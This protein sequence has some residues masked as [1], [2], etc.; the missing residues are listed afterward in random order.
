MRLKKIK[1]EMI[2]IFVL[3]GIGFLSVVYLSHIAISKFIIDQEIQKARLISHTLFYTR[4]YLSKIAP[5]VKL[6]DKHIHPFS[7]APAVTVSGIAK[8]IKKRENFIIRQTSDRYRNINNKPNPNEIKAIEFF[9][10]NPNQQELFELEKDR[11][12][13][14][15]KR[16]Y[17]FYPLKITQDCL[18]CHGTKKDMEPSLY[19][20][21]VDV[22]GE[23][24]FGYKLGDIRG[25]I[26][27]DIPLKK[28]QTAINT[29]F[30]ILALVLFVF[31]IIGVYLF[32]R[33]NR[34]IVKDMDTINAHF[35]KY[36]SKNIFKLLKSQLYY[37]EFENMKLILNNSI[38]SIKRLQK[39][40]Y[41]K[42]YYN[43]L[44]NLPNRELLI[45]KLSRTKDE[46]VGLILVDVDE[47]KDIN[48]Q[49]GE[50]IADR[51]V[52]EMANRL[53][54]YKVYHI[55]IDQFA[56][57]TY[58]MSESEIYE[59]SKKILNLLEKPYRIDEY[60]IYIK[61]RIGI[62]FGD[63][64]LMDVIFTL[65]ATK[66]LN[67]DIVFYKEAR[68]VKVMH[69]EHSLWFK[70]IKNALEEDRIKA[71]YQPIVDENG[72]I[73]KYEALVRLI[74][75]DG[76]VITPYFFLDIAKKSRLYFDITRTVIIQTFEKFRDK[77][78]E[79]SINLSTNDLSNSEIR[80]FIIEKVREFPN[81]NRINFEIIEDEDIKELNEANKFLKDLKKEGCKI[82]ID[83]FGS[84]YANFDYLL[85]LNADTIKIDG[86][87]IRNVL[88]DKHSEIIVKTIITFA[89]ESKKRVIA[90]YVENQEIFEKLKDMGV[91]FFQGYYFSIPLSNTEDLDC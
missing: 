58:G 49:Y 89:K 27:V 88:R 20:K 67:K 77:D 52:I 44:T 31:Y 68:E 46:T 19:K 53:E 15:Y 18:K 73:I 86:S 7:L 1:N 76:K 61:I 12:K 29:I 3:S 16:L 6:I 40:S 25:V 70:K 62:S 63:K 64:D 10:K 2:A 87:L 79:I 75:A 4:E 45:K 21:L 47:F 56:I 22:Y 9:K 83:D 66:I 78:C 43:R 51:L 72:K 57:V 36:F 5:Y 55:K 11:D 48:F 54:E 33:I 74:D 23:R 50:D 59:Y 37:Y 14:R 8:V 91:D 35:E 80:K 32:L 84:G 28:A 82:S 39:E 65:D 17:Y 34:K 60:E 69:Q 85:N 24:A 42:T 71:Y 26:S 38:I 81:P 41:L 90:E 13:G 30:F